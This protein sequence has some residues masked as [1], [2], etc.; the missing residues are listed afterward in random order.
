LRI[1]TTLST[2]TGA[3]AE[4]LPCYKALRAEVCPDAIII[5]A[6]GSAQSASDWNRQAI[7]EA[8]G[9]PRD[10]ACGLTKVN[11]QV[12]VGPQDVYVFYGGSVEN[13]ST[14]I[15]CARWDGAESLRDC[16]VRFE[17][18]GLSLRYTFAKSQLPHW[19]RIHTGVRAIVKSFEVGDSQ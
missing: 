11:T 4:T 5:L 2:L 6:H 12:S 16:S 19:R 10:D 14:V 15:A 8:A 13:N 7:I 17:I 3:A 18:S 1:V 9:D